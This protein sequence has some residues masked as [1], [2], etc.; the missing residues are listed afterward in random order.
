MSFPQD[1]KR[2][3]H[4]LEDVT[5]EVPRMELE[6]VVSQVRL[7]KHATRRLKCFCCW[8]L[9]HFAASDSFQH[10]PSLSE[11]IILHNRDGA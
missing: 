3:P 7:I 5:L 1:S 8:L 10:K 11:C 6:S 4:G 9:Q 2:Y